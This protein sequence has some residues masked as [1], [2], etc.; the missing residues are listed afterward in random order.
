MKQGGS[1]DMKIL[2]T[3]LLAFLG[4]MVCRV[5]T[6]EARNGIGQVQDQARS[7]SNAQDYLKLLSQRLDLTEIQ[8]ARIKVILQDQF[9]RAQAVRD[10]ASLSA[11]N[12]MSKLRSLHEATDAKVRSLLNDRQKSAFDEMQQEMTLH[13]GTGQGEGN[14]SE[15]G[16]GLGYG[17]GRGCQMPTVNEHLALLSEKLDLSQ[18]Q[19]EKI[20]ALLEGQLAHLR[21]IRNEESLSP[22]DKVNKIRNLREA[23]A[24]MVRERLT[25]DQRKKFDEMLTNADEI[26]KERRERGEDCSMIWMVPKNN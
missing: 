15:Q 13:V 11:E 2:R 1:I 23:S 14:G 9:E 22:Q 17:Q 26:M 6:T 8:R 20:Q 25:N 21:S 10:D 3:A 24:T 7:I 16:A 19:Q 18:P 5:S 4:L 12:K